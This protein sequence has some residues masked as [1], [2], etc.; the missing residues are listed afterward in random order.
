M[1]HRSGYWTFAGLVLV[2]ACMFPET[3]HALE[4]SPAGA[5]PLSG[6]SDADGNHGRLPYHFDSGLSL[7][8]VL[9]ALTISATLNAAQRDRQIIGTRLA[10]LACLLLVAWFVSSW[11]TGYLKQPRL[12]P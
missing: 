6:E 11:F 1:G 3:V 10:A 4:D 7:V 8:I 2:L 9:F 5:A 12:I